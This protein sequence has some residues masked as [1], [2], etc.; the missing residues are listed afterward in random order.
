M[1]MTACYKMGVRGVR[2][3]QRRRTM[4][5]VMSN[6]LDERINIGL[7]KVGYINRFRLRQ[8]FSSYVFRLDQFVTINRLEHLET[9]SAPPGLS[10]SVSNSNLGESV[11]SLCG[12]TK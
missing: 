5:D 9:M 4:Q 12:R 1:W 3:C 10:V 8:E 7:Q 6:R 11:H 2:K